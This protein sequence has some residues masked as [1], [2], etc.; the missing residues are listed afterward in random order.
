[1]VALVRSRQVAAAVQGLLV[2]HQTVVLALRL[3]LPGLPLPE[4]EV[5]AVVA[6]LLILPVLVAQ[7]EVALVAPMHQE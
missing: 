7:G 6:I 4:Q 5:V 1:M 2:A 3:Q